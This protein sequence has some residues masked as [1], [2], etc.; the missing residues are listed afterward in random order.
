MVVSVGCDMVNHQE[1]KNLGW[2]DTNFNL[3]RIFTDHEI[4]QF[5]SIRKIEYLAGRFATKCKCPFF[6]TASFRVISFFN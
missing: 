3:G 5:Q 2:L 1:T 6:Q 4:S